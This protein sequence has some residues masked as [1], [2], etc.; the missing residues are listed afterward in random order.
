MDKDTVQG[1]S[2]KHNAIANEAPYF[3]FAGTSGRDVLFQ[4][5]AVISSFSASILSKT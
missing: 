4:P 1:Y 3:L 2:E 5:R